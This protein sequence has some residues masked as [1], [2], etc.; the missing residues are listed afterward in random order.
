MTGTVREPQAARWPTRHPRG[1]GAANQLACL[2]HAGGT[3]GLFRSRA[4][5]DRH[6]PELLWARLPGGHDRAHCGEGLSR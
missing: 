1:G 4:V 2:P 3:L 5:G 6:G